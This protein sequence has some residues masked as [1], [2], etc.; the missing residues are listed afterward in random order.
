MDDITVVVVGGPVSLHRYL[1]H[2]QLCNFV[3]SLVPLPH[4]WWER[5]LDLI[6]V[7]TQV[8]INKG[9][10]QHAL[11]VAQT[12]SQFSTKL[13]SMSNHDNLSFHDHNSVGHANAT[14]TKSGAHKLMQKQGLGI[15]SSTTVPAH[16][17]RRRAH[18]VYPPLLLHFPLSSLHNTI[19][20]HQ[21]IL[22]TA[23]RLPNPTVPGSLSTLLN[24][25]F[26]FEVPLLLCFFSFFLATIT[27][28]DDLVTR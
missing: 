26:C 19:S 6:Y 27:G 1:H 23:N 12:K 10:K 17:K 28:T 15:N 16:N 21:S 3:A 9:G 22:A 20:P 13:I 7:T 8:F 2:L 18:Q 24:R 4:K 5:V 14:K 11:L 25:I